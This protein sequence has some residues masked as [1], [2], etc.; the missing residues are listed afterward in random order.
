MG[1]LVSRVFA[2]DA[3]GKLI[4]QTEIAQLLPDAPAAA[5]CHDAEPE[6]ASQKPEGGA[7]A[8]KQ[9]RAL[10]AIGVSP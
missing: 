2:K 9:G 10:R 6:V 5:R 1:L 8:G 4:A 3:G 7:G